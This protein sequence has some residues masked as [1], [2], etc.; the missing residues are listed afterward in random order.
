MR[1]SGLSEY[2]HVFNPMT[3]VLRKETQR[4]GDQE[5]GKGCVKT[6]ADIKIIHSQSKKARK[7]GR[8]LP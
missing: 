5:E 7:Q 8:I 1:S 2:R 3:S 4:R 6:E